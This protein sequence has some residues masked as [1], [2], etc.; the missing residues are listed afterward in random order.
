MHKA[1]TG[2]PD[3]YKQ[4]AS[5]DKGEMARLQAFIGAIAIGD[6]VKSTLGPKGMDKIL[7]P[8][9]GQGRTGNAT[10]TNDGATILKSVWIDNPAARILVDISKTQDQECGDGTTSV[11]VLAAEMLRN[12][13]QLVEQQKMHPQVIIRGYR[14]A[15]AAAR[16]RLASLAMDNG[17]NS[18][19][20][21]EDLLRIARTT[22]SSKLLKHEKDHFATLAVNA[23]LRLGGKPNIDY[24]QVIKKAGGSLKESFLSEG[25]ILEK[26]IAVGHKKTLEN[27]KVLVANCQMDTDKIKIYG[28]KVKV[29]SFEAV[30]EIEA[31]EKEKMKTKIGK[32]VG[33]GCNVFINRQLI[34]N[35]PDQL[36]KENGVMA[37]E[38][39]DFD[40]SERLAA[41]LGADIVSTFESP[42]Q[43]KLGKC[44]KIEEIMI[45]ED[46]VIKFSGCAQGEACTI[47]L[48]GSSQHVLDEAERS[49]HDALAVLYQ[50]VQE[51]RVVWGGGSMEMAMAQAV[52]KKL[53]EVGGKE[54]V[55][56]EGFA[57]ALMQ[58]P[59]ILAD[60]AGLDSAELVGQLRAAHAKG[61][62]TMGLDFTV[63]DVQ[64]MKEKGIMESFRSKMSQLC[65]ASEAAEMIVRV[66]DIIKNAPRQREG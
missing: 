25:F 17:K 51:T 10:V 58:I 34:Y 1:L 48:R 5:E 50:T 49:L 47:V 8:V 14:L 19:A 7:Q 27:C 36:F 2:G 59:T 62:N 35:Y 38:H 3:V 40:G 64:D 54:S 13:Q 6:M 43:T 46:K 39:S 23:V 4:G 45:G 44:D 57:K 61:G 53:N 29:D 11:V 18:E 63:G 12:A 55:A 37:I 32:I 30:A 20:F 65:S 9:S 24:I 66:D 21:R 41:V 22:L 15:L 26:R 16:E 52:Q 31:A 42:E 60:N 56:M 28:A 33:H